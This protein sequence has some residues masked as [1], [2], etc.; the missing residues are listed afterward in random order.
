MRKI[1]AI[2]TLLSAGLVAGCH[3]APEKHYPVR[4]EVISTDSSNKLITVKHGD[5]PGLMPAMTMA[6]QVA[7]PKQLE[8]LKPGDNITADLVV[9]ENNARLEKIAVVSKGDAK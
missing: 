5:I 9:S 3:S 2:V 6:Y 7:E 4:G 1:L 8:T